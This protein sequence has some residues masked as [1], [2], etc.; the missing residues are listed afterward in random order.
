MRRGEIEARHAGIEELL[1][2]PLIR[3]EI[4]DTLK[5]IRD[6]ERIE[7][8]VAAE[9]ASPLDLAALRESLL[10]LP[11]LIEWASKLDADIFRGI[12]EGAQALDELAAHLSDALV[13]NP[14]ANYRDGGVFADGFSAELDRLRDAARGGKEWIAKLQQKER[15][16]TGIRNLR[17]GYNKVFGYYLEIS[18]ANMHMAPK[19]YIRKQTLVNAERFITEE[20]KSMEE[21]ILGAE[22][23][24]NA[25]E[26]EMY[27]QLL[28]RIAAERTPL[29][30][31][32]SAIAL[33]D[34]LVSFA[35]CAAQYNWCR[36]QISEGM[37]LKIDAGRHP[38][39]EITQR[40][41]PFVPNDAE[42][43]PDEKQL[44][45]ITGPNMAGKS[46]Y[47]RQIALIA[48]LNQIGSYV[49]A[50][51]ASLPIFDAIFQV[52]PEIWRAW[53]TNP[54]TD[55][56]DSL[57]TPYYGGNGLV[58]QFTFTQSEGNHVIPAPPAVFLGLLGAGL[59]TWAHRRR[60]Q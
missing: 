35:E 1:S 39:I 51:S 5:G 60:I 53:T 7:S 52:S 41:E 3:A 15:E 45:I 46:T 13:A 25:L 8:R 11:V 50:T 9:T 42:F 55:G 20:L 38:V 10:R 47:L 31:A 19:H 56:V 29:L 12:F 58:T 36:P 43:D 54:D 23:K 28:A 6:I 4:A 33:L 14:P 37:S 17:I 49:P 2:R 32:A 59:V 22:E 30:K 16:L 21:E 34:V 40:D 27:A 44:N 26:A 57:T 18:K 24:A 48:F